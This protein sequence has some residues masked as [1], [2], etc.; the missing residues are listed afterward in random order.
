MNEVDGKNHQEPEQP[1]IV[2]LE[3]IH[4]LIDLRVV[5]AATVSPLEV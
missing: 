2:G 5:A 3:R 1:P 4:L